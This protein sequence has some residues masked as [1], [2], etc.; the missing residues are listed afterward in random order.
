MIIAAINGIRT[1]INMENKSVLKG[2]EIFSTFKRKETIGAK[3]NNIV[4]SF[5]AT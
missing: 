2:T 4:R 3:A 5:I 1:K